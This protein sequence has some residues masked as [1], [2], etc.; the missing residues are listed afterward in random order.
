MNLH[1]IMIM[2]LCLDGLVQ[3]WTCGIVLVLNDW[4]NLA[5]K[6]KKLKE[7]ES[8]LQ[9]CHKLSLG[10]NWNPFNVLWNAVTCYSMHYE[11]N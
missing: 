11:S 4:K 7:I 3:I 10:S 8:F 6:S 1:Q 9:N 5:S 2:Q